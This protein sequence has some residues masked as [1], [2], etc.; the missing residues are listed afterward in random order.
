VGLTEVIAAQAAVKDVIW[1]DLS[2]NLN[3]LPAVK[4]ASNRD[5]TARR[6][7]SPSALCQ[8]T[9]LTSMGLK[10]LLQS[11]QD[12]YDFV[13][14]DLA[15]ITPVADVKAISHLI[16]SFI[17]VI[18]LGRTS[19]EAVI[20]ALD[21]VPSLFEKLLGAVLNQHTFRAG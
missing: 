5:P 17:L 8:R 11:I 19:Q 9:Q 7:L 1:H 16:D 10:T 3:F 4:V 20:D 6:M 18:E 14:L 12:A 15:S 13:I 21:S 2:T